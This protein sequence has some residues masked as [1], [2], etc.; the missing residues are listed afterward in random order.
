MDVNG[1]MELYILMLLR[2]LGW[3]NNVFSNK[4]GGG[5]AD[6]ITWPLWQ[7]IMNCSWEIMVFASLL[8]NHMAALQWFQETRVQ[9]LENPLT[10]GFVH[11][12]ADWIALDSAWWRLR[13]IMNYDCVWSQ[14][15]RLNSIHRALCRASLVCRLF[16]VLSDPPGGVFI[17]MWGKLYA[18]WTKL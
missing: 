4:R 18:Q 11:A 12:I 6:N 15:C 5:N 10:S 3:F 1:N 9:Q 16:L 14:W 7:H 8:S 2:K 17:T 13:C